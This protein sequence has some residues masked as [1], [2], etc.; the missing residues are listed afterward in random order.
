VTLAVGE[1]RELLATAFDARGDNV[2]TANFVWVSSSPATVR[3]EADPSMPGIAAV[4]GV[5]DGLANVEVRVGNKSASTVIQVSGGGGG[6]GP[7]AP[8]GAATVL[9][10][11]PGSVFLLPTEDVDLQARFLTDDGSLA[12]PSAVT[13]R[14]LTANIAA[15]SPQGSVVGLATGQGVIEAVSAGGLISRVTVQ[16]TQTPFEFGREVLAVS[17]EQADTVAVVVP[18]QNNRLLEPRRLTWRTTDVTVARV[19]PVGVVTGV[20]AGQ[21]ELVVSGYGQQNRLAI[22]VHRPVEFLDLMPDRGRGPVAVPLGGSVQ[23]SAEARAADETLVPEA[24]LTWILPDTSVTAFDPASGNLTGKA[25][26]ETELTVRAPGEGLEGTWQVRVIEGGLSLDTKRKTLGMGEVHRLV[27]SFTD[28]DGSPVSEASGVTWTSTDPAVIE[29]DELGNVQ[30][31]GFGAAAVVVSTPWG[32][33]DTAT[34]WVKFSLRTP[35]L[36]A[37]LICTHS[38][39]ASRTRC[40]ALPTNPAANWTPGF[41]LME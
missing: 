4:I 16:V 39:Q 34:R 35:A 20:G 23:F 15:V 6:A 10:I 27:A 5:A 19:S 36:T 14:S 17:P 25:L 29:V 13:W 12:N 24:Q 30:P 2:A 26:G 40:T 8:A 1:R 31:A 18:E 7:V 38:I 32:S 28:H 37:E 33:A 22:T 3:V 21:T 9:Q 41:P 11:E